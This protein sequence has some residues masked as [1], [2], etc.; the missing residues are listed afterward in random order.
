ME[1]TYCSD[2]DTSGTNY[3]EAHSATVTQHCMR[4]PSKHT[5]KEQTLLT[6][7]CCIKFCKWI[8]IQQQWLCTPFF[9]IES[10]WIC[11]VSPGV[12]KRH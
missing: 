11:T 9:A 4:P 6:T 7:A 12:S 10:L 5:K 3:N 2:V 8:A 1:I